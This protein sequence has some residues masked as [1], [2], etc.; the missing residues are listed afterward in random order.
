MGDFMKKFVAGTAAV[1]TLAGVAG[2]V[3]PALSG[4]TA[5]AA[6]KKTLTVGFVPSNQADTMEARAKPLA[7]LLS[8]ELGGRKVKVVVSTDY[9]SIVEA[10]GSGTLD[11]GFL[12]PDAYVQAHKEYKAKLLLQTQRYGVNKEDG[13]PTKKLVNWYK[14]E[15]L[16]HAD[17][18]I[19]DVADLKGK[20]IAVQ[21]VSSSSG[22]IFPAY[23]LNSKGVNI[24]KD[25]TLQTVKGHDQGVLAVVSKQDDAAFVFQDARNLVKKDNPSVFKD[26]KVLALSMKI[27]ND[28]V[29]ARADLD[30]A[31]RTKVTNG[32][33][34]IAKTKKGHDLVKNLYSIEGFAKGK[35]SNFNVVRKAAD[36]AK[37]Q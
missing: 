27:P 15:I 8:K 35:D 16:V 6:S 5:D 23:Y 9:N 7:K 29:T 28:T 25:A 10:L 19:K 30:K 3:A 14:S 21:D 1:L 26:T 2:T 22:Y 18:D 33:I 4:V 32:L 17:S 20:T 37:A 13:S 11:V 12:P 36:W 24:T 31:T 34:K